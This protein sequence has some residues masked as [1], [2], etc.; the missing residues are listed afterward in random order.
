LT[1]TTPPPAGEV[2]KQNKISRQKVGDDGE[3][4]RRRNLVVEKL[5]TIK[6]K[7]LSKNDYARLVLESLPSRYR[8]SPQ[9][10]NALIKWARNREIEI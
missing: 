5:P 3:D 1:S 2:S 10:P 7:K 6:N 4:V 9:T 8:H